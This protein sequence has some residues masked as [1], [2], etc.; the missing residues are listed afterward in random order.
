MQRYTLMVWCCILNT[1]TNYTNTLYIYIYICMQNHNDYTIKT[2]DTVLR[3]I[4]L[5]L[6]LKGLCARGS[7]RPNRTAT[8]W[9]PLMAI[10]VSFPFSWAAQPGAWGPASL[11]AGFLYRIL[12]LTGLV[13]KLLNREFR[14]PLLLGCCFSLSHL[15]S[16]WL[17]FLCTVLYDSSTPTFL[18]ASQLHSFNLSTVKVIILIFF[19]RMH[20]LFTQV[21]FLF[22]QPGRVVGL[23][24]N[25][26][27]ALWHINHCRLFDD[28]SIFI[29]I[30]SS[31]SNNSI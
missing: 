7:W 14:G 11:G 5:S 9:P 3:K 20:L 2:S 19:D 30:S 27:L 18:W 13:S 16:N 15:V 23:I 10:S 12:S 8:Y 6:Y 4:Y 24:Y 31:I 21:H 28:E 1:I 17:N 29:H 22:W 25:I 26:G